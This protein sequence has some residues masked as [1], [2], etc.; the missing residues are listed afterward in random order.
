MQRAPSSNV[1]HLCMPG[2]A[3]A[4]TASLWQRSSWCSM[5]AW[6]SCLATSVRLAGKYLSWMGMGKIVSNLQTPSLL[7]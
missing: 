4:L 2:A 3:G 6:T 1:P 7:R 5:G